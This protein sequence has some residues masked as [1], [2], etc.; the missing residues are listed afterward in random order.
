MTRSVVFGAAAGT[1]LLALGITLWA[2]AGPAIFNAFTAFG[3]LICA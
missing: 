3:Q 2:A 1:F